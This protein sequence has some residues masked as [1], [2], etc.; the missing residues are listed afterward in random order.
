MV[1]KMG[2]YSMAYFKIVFIIRVFIKVIANYCFIAVTII[3]TTTA[4]V[5]NFTTFIEVN[6]IN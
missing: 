5:T 1:I 4:V 6:F 3:V 2:L